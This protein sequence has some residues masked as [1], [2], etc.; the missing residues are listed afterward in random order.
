VIDK[1]HGLSR[2]EDSFRAIKGDLEGRPVY[3]RGKGHTN[4]HFLVCF[5]AL[6]MIRLLQYMILKNEGKAT[7]STRGWEM[8]IPAGRIKKAL[9]E[10]KADALP[11]GFY[12]LTKSED[13]SDLA[14]IAAA[15][16]VDVALRLPSES[17]IRKLKYA[18]DKAI[19]M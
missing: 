19:F 3:V 5:I 11:G 1:Y 10:F 6:T 12:R 16:G 8:G 9:A 18:I 17:E 13:G 4:A 15:V 14:R 2:I 7:N